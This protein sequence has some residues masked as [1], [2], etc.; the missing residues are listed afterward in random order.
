MDNNNN[1][2]CQ[3]VAQGSVGE[4]GASTL[5]THTVEAEYSKMIVLRRGDSSLCPN[6]GAVAILVINGEPVASGNITDSKCSVAYEGAPGDHVVAIIHS[7]PLFNDITC[8]R[9][10]DLDFTL[11]EC[12]LVD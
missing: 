4:S 12:D 11:S 10:G 6:T 9:L 5:L 3:V 2:V 1:S 7:I 8:F